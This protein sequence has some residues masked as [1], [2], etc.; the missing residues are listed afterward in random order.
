MTYCPKKKRRYRLKPEK[1]PSTDYTQLWRVIDGA[2]RDAIEHHP[3]YLSDKGRQYAS[4]RRSIVKRAVGAVLG[5]QAE[6][7]SG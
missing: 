4:A 2:V 6:R 5:Y 3:D 1:K 7:R